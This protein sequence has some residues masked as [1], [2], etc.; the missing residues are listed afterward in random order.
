MTKKN[1]DI[2][3]LRV[4]FQQIKAHKRRYYIVLPIVFVVSCALILCVPRYY[5]TSMSLA[6]EAESQSTGGTLSSI[7]SSF[8]FDLNDIQTSDAIYPMLYPDLMD[9]NAFVS[10][11]FSIHVKSQDGTIDTNYFDYLKKHQKYPWWTLAI[12]SI[13]QWISKENIQP[14]NARNEASFDPY[15][16]GK[17]E[18][19]VLSAIRS[20]VSFAYDKKTSVIT[21]NVTDQDP[22]I[23]KTIADS[24]KTHLQAFITD[25][26][27][28]KARVDME[29][30]EKMAEEA[31]IEYEESRR[32]YANF[33]DANTNVV[34]QSYRNKLE[35]MENDMQM[36]FNAYTTYQAQLQNAKARVQERTPAFTMIKGASI[37][38]QPAGP[39]RM[40][41]VAGMVIFAF[42][43][44]T[45]LIIKK[46][47][48]QVIAKQSE[49]EANEE[50]NE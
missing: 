27:T 50:A 17:Y 12:G 43:I 36:K 7:A 44:I 15:T 45:F 23:C 19:S 6:P 26:R 1:T 14:T 47:I 41:F 13:K 46:H 30:Y 3:D 48:F 31:K 22:L 32:A 4:I 20:H 28:N 49:N 39:K 2:I 25:Y 9:D 10:K 29:Y 16:V 37:P 33:A 18:E 24:V 42:F 21:I 38:L 5:T 40:F 11:F 34:L 8:G 35:D